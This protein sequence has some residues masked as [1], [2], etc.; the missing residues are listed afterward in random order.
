MILVDAESLVIG[1]DFLEIV[2]M[3]HYSCDMISAGGRAESS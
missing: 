3:F 2:D 1:S